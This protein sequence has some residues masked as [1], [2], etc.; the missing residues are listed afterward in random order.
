MVRELLGRLRARFTT[1]SFQSPIRVTPPKAMLSYSQ[2]MESV[3]VDKRSHENISYTFETFQRT[4]WT[5]MQAL[6]N[7]GKVAEPLQNSASLHEEI[8]WSVQLVPCVLGQCY[9]GRS[10]MG[11]LF[12]VQMLGPHW[13]F[14][15]RCWDIC[16]TRSQASQTPANSWWL[17]PPPEPGPSVPSFST[18][19]L[20]RAE[21]RHRGLRQAPPVSL[22]FIPLL[23]C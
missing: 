12:A 18:S 20:R 7:L 5:H 4:S 22:P 13:D 23:S 16:Q 19:W 11:N 14:H 8:R 1:T 2:L 17:L 6:W 3:S 21:E 9:P 15:I 10:E